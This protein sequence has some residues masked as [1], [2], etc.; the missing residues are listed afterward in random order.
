MIFCFVFK[1]MLLKA[2]DSCLHS[3]HYCVPNETAYINRSR[4]TVHMIV[5]IRLPFY[6][7]LHSTLCFHGVLCVIQ[8]TFQSHF[9]VSQLTIGREAISTM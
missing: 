1:H 4:V 3:Y 5:G 2:F 6:S 8:F 7:V 9:K